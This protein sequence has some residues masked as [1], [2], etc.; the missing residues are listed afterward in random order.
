MQ[1][2]SGAGPYDAVTNQA[3]G[4]ARMFLLMLIGVFFN[5]CIPKCTVSAFRI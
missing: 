4:W 5:F 2:L 1:L 3:L